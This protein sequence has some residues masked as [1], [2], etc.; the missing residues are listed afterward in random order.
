MEA[1]TSEDHLKVQKMKKKVLRKQVRAQHTLMR[2]EGIKCVSHVTQSLVIAN[3][4][5]GNG[6]SRQQLLRILEEYGAMETL[7]MPPNKPYSFVKYR[8]TEEAKKAFNAL[9]GKEVT[10]EDCDQN[11]VLYINFV[12][13]VSLQ[14]A[15]PTSLPPGLV[16]I[17]K[18]ISPEEERRMLESVDWKADEDTQNAQ[19]TLKHRRVKHFGYEFRYDN[20]NV[21]KDKPLPGGIPP[22][23]D[24]H[25]A[26]EDEIISL[27]LGAE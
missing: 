21:D 1:K 4:G 15:V 10:L 11:I 20:N 16:V 5:L 27:S 13:K 19:K 2:H 9:N 6:M 18:I 3:A 8:T 23:T 26:F 12:E 25:S 24:T 22:H 7:L 14:N 17:E